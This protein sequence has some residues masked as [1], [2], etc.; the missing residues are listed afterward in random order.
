MTEFRHRL[1]TLNETWT[2]DLADD[3]KLVETSKYFLQLEQY[4]KYF[5][6]SDILIL[7]FDELRDN[8]RQVLQTTY[9]FLEISPDYFPED[10]QVVNS[11]RS[12]PK[13]EKRLRSLKLGG[14]FGSVTQTVG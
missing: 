2:L 3:P 9:E 6:T 4:R 1:I 8:P 11:T 7:D 13:L 5:P 10:Y 12:V 14:H